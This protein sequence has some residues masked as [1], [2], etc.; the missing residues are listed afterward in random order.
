MSII[1]LGLIYILINFCIYPEKYVTTW[2]YQLKQD[3][4]AGDQQAIE[5]YQ[6]NYLEKGEKL[7]N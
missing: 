5:Y 7:W 2:K 6:K 3:I 1:I 4:E